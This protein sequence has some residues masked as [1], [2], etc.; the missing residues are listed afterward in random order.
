MCH[1]PQNIVSGQTARPQTPALPPSSISKDP[2]TELF[3]RRYIREIL[4]KE[5]HRMTR[6]K[7]PLAIIMFDL[8][9]FKE[10]NDNYGHEAGDLLLRELAENV[11][12]QIR[13][14]DFACRYGGRGIR[15]R[16]A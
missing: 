12:T 14:D 1:T 13:E 11:R 6:R 3:N 10:F 5:V 16:D 8:D 15:D 2:L 7:R 9:H 4:E